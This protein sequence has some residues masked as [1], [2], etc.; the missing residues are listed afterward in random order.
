M[1]N[2][3]S[4]GGAGF[5]AGGGSGAG[6]GSFESILRIETQT[7]GSTLAAFTPLRLSSGQ[8][9]AA[10]ATTQ[11]DS[12]VL[13]LS[14]ASVVSGAEFSL[15]KNGLV[16]GA[17]SS[18]TPGRRYYLSPSGGLT[19]TVPT[20][21]GQ[22]IVEVGRAVSSTDLWVDVQ[23]PSLIPVIPSSGD[24]RTIDF[25]PINEEFSEEIAR[26]LGRMGSQI[27][28]HHFILDSTYYVWYR[29]GS[30]GFDPGTS[31]YAAELS[32]LTGI[33][34]TL[35][36]GNVTAAAV[37][38][39]T[40]SAIDGVGSYTAVATGGSITVQELTTVAAGGTSYSASGAAGVFGNLDNRMIGLNSFSGATL[41]A[42]QFDLTRLPATPFIITGL[43]L[44]IG[45]THAGQCAIAI[46]Q[47]GP[48]DG[49]YNTATLLGTI[50]STT[51]SGT[52]EEQ[53]IVCTDGVLVDPSAG[54]LWVAWAHQA[55]AFEMSFTWGSQPQ[56]S[57]VD[58]LLTG[59]Q[60]SH[61][62]TAG[63]SFSDVASF[64]GTLGSVA[65]SELGIPSFMFSYVS[66]TFHSDMTPVGR[67]GTREQDGSLFLGASSA[68]LLV[69]NSFTTPNLLGMEVLSASV[70]YDT[71]VSGSDYRL[72]IATG[73][74]ADN[75]FNGAVWQDIGQTTGT[76]L[77][78]V[79]V[80]APS[81]VSIAP[82]SRVFITIEFDGG[83]SALAFDD[84]TAPG[85]YG[86]QNINPAAYY[87]GGSTESEVDDGSLG[88]TATTTVDFDP[89]TALV[90]TQ[91]FDGTIYNNGNHVGVRMLYHIP[92]F[93]IQ[94]AV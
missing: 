33:Q 9:V 80:D 48:A 27:V 64:P 76:S 82:S 17:I 43:R 31:G 49:D 21:P 28:G 42:S 38:T 87:N 70:N 14:I 45:D 53:F 25:G 83:A 55:G 65:A 10:N 3:F 12:A 20:T 91:T 86:D 36:A 78:W 94:P 81:G 4:S 93:V 85:A 11:A 62:M 58:Y 2:G 68:P 66:T 73:G 51:G 30:A 24:E 69:G 29:H 16:V 5:G 89:S 39:A 15:V 22:Y 56:A 13:G 19:V 72:E 23:A 32:G 1:T 52:D 47:G 71:H 88:G 74:T 84:D 6:D 40:A 26:D 8:Y 90:G 18:A 57:D 44:G 7:A 59:G 34:V 50:G 54:R 35:P 60:G 92:G 67:I 63:T 46:Y 37:A 41:R 61:V 75:N 79:D 77:G